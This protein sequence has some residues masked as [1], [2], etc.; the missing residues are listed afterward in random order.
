MSQ[1]GSGYLHLR[2]TQTIQHASYPPLP[3]ESQSFLENINLSEH[4]HVTIPPFQA[5]PISIF[6]IGI[7]FQDSDVP[8][9]FNGLASIWQ[10]DDVQFWSLSRGPAPQCSRQ[11]SLLCLLQAFQDLQASCIFHILILKLS[12]SDIF[13]LRFAGKISIVGNAS[14]WREA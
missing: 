5:L 8:R 3:K 4:T 9:R 2:T 10:Q 1:L 7:L 12:N 13:H 6:R 11:V 14:H